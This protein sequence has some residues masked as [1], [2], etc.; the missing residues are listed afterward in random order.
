M[1]ENALITKADLCFGEICGTNGR[2]FSL[3]L[4]LKT[5]YGGVG[6]TFNPMKL[7]QLLEQL[8]LEKFSELEGTYVQ[9]MDTALGEECKGIS[10]FVAHDRAEV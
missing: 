1:T 9:I 3:K 7:P 8:G 10:G 4:Q 2:Q 5:T 6:V